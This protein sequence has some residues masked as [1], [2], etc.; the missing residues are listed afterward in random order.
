MVFGSHQ[1]MDKGRRI[2]VSSY[3]NGQS[4]C[5]V[6][7][8]QLGR[9]TDECCI[10]RHV[11]AWN[12]D[13]FSSVGYYFNPVEVS[14]MNMCRFDMK[15]GDGF[16]Q[17]GFTLL[18]TLVSVAIIALV[19]V[20]LSQVF[21]S[22]MRTNTKTEILK[23]VKQ[24]GDLAIESITRMVQNAQ[25]VTCP[26]AKSLAVVNPDGNTT[27]VSCQDVSSVARLASSSATTTVYL[28]S[29]N[30]TLGPVCASSSL[31]FVCTSVSGLPSLVTVSFQ[32]A[33]IGTPVDQFETA[34]ETFQ[35]SVTMR[36]NQ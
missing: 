30:V 6:Y 35:T 18:E 23:E 27:T 20:V 25:S 9:L 19:S 7:N 16:R 34:S 5:P 8:L 24:S 32:M 3:S 4:V 12:Q 2:R 36:N 29:Q 21:I 28:S 17:N 14:V 15:H 26:T 22:T 31:Q 13:G 10:D 1:C 33:Q 11:D